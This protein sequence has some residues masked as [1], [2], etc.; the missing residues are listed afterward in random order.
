MAELRAEGAVRDGNPIGRETVS[1][2]Q[3]SGHSQ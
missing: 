1:T 2:K 3:I